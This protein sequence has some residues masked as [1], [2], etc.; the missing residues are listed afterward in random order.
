MVTRIGINGFGRIGRNVLRAGWDRTD[1]EFVHINDL[2]SDEMLALAQDMGGSMEYV[3]GVGS[4][5]THL[6]S[7]ELG[8]GL[9]V[10]RAI[11]AALDPHHVMNPGN[12]GL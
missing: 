2:T 10:L 6:V 9:D 8:V 11:K 1:I 12:L 3:H 5:L 4:K 7:R